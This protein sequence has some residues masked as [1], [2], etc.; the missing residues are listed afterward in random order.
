MHINRMIFC[1]ISMP[2]IWVPMNSFLTDAQYFFLCGFE[3]GQKNAMV[4]VS[5]SSDRSKE[6]PGD[7]KVMDEA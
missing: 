7:Q 1:T 5:D 4:A 3:T 6:K 2:K